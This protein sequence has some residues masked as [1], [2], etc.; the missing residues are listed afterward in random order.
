MLFVFGVQ[1]KAFNKNREKGSP[2][3]PCRYYYILRYYK[4]GSS[5]IVPPP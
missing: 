2:K 1:K 5:I 3:V 4:Q